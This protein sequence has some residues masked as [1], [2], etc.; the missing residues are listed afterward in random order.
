M[1]SLRTKIVDML[2][3]EWVTDFEQ[4]V[5][6]TPPVESAAA[7]LRIGRDLDVPALVA[8]GYY[9]LMAR[10]F[11]GVRIAGISGWEHVYAEDVM[12]LFAGRERIQAKVASD[13]N[14]SLVTRVSKDSCE[15]PLVFRMVKERALKDFNPLRSL[16]VNA[17]N[18]Q[19][20]KLLDELILMND[21]MKIRLCNKCMSDCSEAIRA[22]TKLLI[23]FLD[24]LVFY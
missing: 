14:A 1:D 19:A 24:R 17:D 10:T 15:L 13:F 6:T 3:K 11:I 7:V 2:K 4:R 5:R 20:G 22:R 12:A 8:P 23:R 18:L 21:S 9:A 16:L